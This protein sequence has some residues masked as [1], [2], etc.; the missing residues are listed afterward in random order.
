MWS[1]SE[2]RTRQ[3]TFYFLIFYRVSLVL[4]VSSYVSSHRTTNRQSST[5][6]VFL[7]YQV[8]KQL[9]IKAALPCFGALDRERISK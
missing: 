8:N 4:R 2:L 5:N 6:T 1:V 7:L 9:V 3:H